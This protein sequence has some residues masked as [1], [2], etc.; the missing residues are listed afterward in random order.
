MGRREQGTGPNL[1]D[2]GV[3]ASDGVHEGDHLEDTIPEGPQACGMTVDDQ[4]ALRREL[5][6]D[7]EKLRCV[8]EVFKILGNP[9]EMDPTLKGMKTDETLEGLEKWVRTPYFQQ[10][11]IFKYDKKATPAGVHQFLK[12][13]IAN[14]NDDC[15]LC[16]DFRQFCYAFNTEV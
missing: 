10:L 3:C 11:R 16:M 5:N 8:K 1:L 9:T 12:S 13:W 6:W 14:S 15:T 4:E 2:M 7:A